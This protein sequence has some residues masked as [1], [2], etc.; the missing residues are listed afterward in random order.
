LKPS[1]DINFTTS[2]G[3]SV[4]EA[5]MALTKIKHNEWK[6]PIRNLSDFSII[7]YTPKIRDDI[8]ISENVYNLS[9]I[10]FWYSLQSSI[11]YSVAKRIWRKEDYYPFLYKGGDPNLPKSYEIIDN[12]LDAQI[13]DIDEGGKLRKL[14]KCHAYFNWMLAPASK[15]SQK[16]LAKMPDHTAGLEAGAHDWVFTKR[17]GGTSPESGFLYER[18]GRVRKQSV[19]GYMDWTEATDK[20]WKR[21]GIAHLK[22]FFQYIKFPKFYGVLTMMLIREPQRVKE[23]HQVTNTP[24]GI[25]KDIIQWNG[26]IREGFM[27]GNR[28]TKTILHLAHTSERSFAQTFLEQKGATVIR[29][30]PNLYTGDNKVP[31]RAE[32][33]LGFFRKS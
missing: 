22:A 3:G 21:I 28:M 16:V 1:A 30:T 27:M 20:M 2:M 9:S 25:E 31:Y 18:T 13:L 17:V 23:I 8:T 6:I 29:G 33:N 24:D 11:N 12:F 19:F 14:V 32:D 15:I 5:R 26:Y 7:N 10:L 4:E